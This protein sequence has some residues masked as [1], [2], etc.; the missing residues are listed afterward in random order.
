[1]NSS[2]SKGNNFKKKFAWLILFIP[3]IFSSIKQS[4]EQTRDIQ[5]N[6]FD[7]LGFSNENVLFIFISNGFVK[8]LIV[9]LI[10]FGITFFETTLNN[11]TKSGKFRSTSLGK[12]K[13][14]EG[15]K[16][17]DIWYFCNFLL[18]GQFPFLIALTTLG[19]SN[20]T[21]GIEKS[22]HDFYLSIIPI[23][24][25]SLTG[26]ILVFL[27]ILIAD[28]SIYLRHRMEHGL[29]FLWDIH[30][31]HHS[32][33]EMTILSKLRES[34]LD[35]I[36]TKPL[37]LPFT[38]FSALLVNENLSQGFSLPFYIYLFFNT[39]FIVNDFIA[40]SSLKFIYPKPLSYIFISP[41]H[42]WLHHSSNP[43]HFNCNFSVG[44]IFW[45]K[46]FGTYI[47]ESHLNDITGYG[48]NNSQYNQNHPLYS[49]NILPLVKV[50]KRITRLAFVR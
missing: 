25:S 20:L 45:D 14:S 38:V 43:K 11:Q 26:S 44:F 7:L 5:G 35:N 29:P 27:S 2:N 1:M 28:F 10:L 40:H 13:I 46:L 47:D 39:F 34:P 8:V 12:L 41:S 50:F 6:I 22:F 32:A 21:N 49:F 3:F 9:V 17:A 30:E 4:L 18:L 36:F 37:I 15:Y 24:S 19:G 16:F 48:V 23:P 42:H 33:T 31:F